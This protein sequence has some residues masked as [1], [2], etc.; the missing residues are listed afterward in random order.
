MNRDEFE[1]DYGQ[2]LAQSGVVNFVARE[3]CDVGRVA[4]GVVLE[5]PPRS[6]W[7][8]SLAAWHILEW[9][10]RQAD[11]AAVYVT[12]GYRSPAYNAAVGGA[13]HSQHI[14]GTARDV[15]VAGRSPV[16]VADTL[17]SHPSAG[18]FGIGR[19]RTFTHFDTRGHRARWGSHD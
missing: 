12:S 18:G 15:R 2:L 1:R 6:I 4:S 7:L 5:A 13:A 10:K 16:W 9:L 11:G 14:A 19:Y 8:E 3:F 17:A